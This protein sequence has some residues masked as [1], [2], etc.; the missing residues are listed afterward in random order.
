MLIDNLR[1]PGIVLSLW[2]YLCGNN[3]NF[4]MDEGLHNMIWLW[5]CY[6]LIAV[7]QW[8]MWRLDELQTGVTAVMKVDLWDC[9]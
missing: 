5:G 7:D 2:V 8:R 3:G 4:F 1:H 9:L 6:W